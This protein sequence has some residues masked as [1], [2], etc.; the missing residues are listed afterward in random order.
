MK[1]IIYL[2]GKNGLLD[3]SSR[4][5]E[6]YEVCQMD[7]FRK[8]MPTLLLK[9]FRRLGYAFSYFTYDKWKYKKKEYDYSIIP[10]G[11]ITKPVLKYL[12]KHPIADKQIVY[13]WNKIRKEDEPLFNYVKKCG[14]TIM[15]YNKNDADKYGILYNSQC[16]DKAYLSDLKPNVEIEQDV[17]FLGYVK[18]RYDIL[19]NIK[20]N[21]EKLDMTTKF[22]MVSNNKQAGTVNKPIQ[23]KD[24]LAE[25]NSSNALLDVVSH[26]NWGLTF[27]P[28]EALFMK[29]KLITNYTDIKDCDF[30]VPY[31]KNIFILGEDDI[32]KLKE[33]VKTP[34]YEPEEEFDLNSYDI[35][36]WVKRFCI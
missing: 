14:Y 17:C 11:L 15:T 36:S 29:K 4:K 9:I 28:L 22:Y 34:F 21:I 3:F 7:V 2:Y 13:Y 32:N 16:W 27:R 19:C 12:S 1:K 30:Y 25:C 8:D 10:D 31:R 6:G 23:Y 33:F 24:Y 18:D 5:I 26:S 20:E 35:E